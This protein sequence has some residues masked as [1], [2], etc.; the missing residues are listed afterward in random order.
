MD[1]STSS[2]LPL[3]SVKPD[4]GFGAQQNSF[5]SALQSV[6]S[7]Q[8]PPSVNITQPIQFNAPTVIVQLKL[9]DTP[10][11]LIC[12]C[13]RAEVITKVILQNTE[14]TWERFKRILCWCPCLCFCC[15]LISCCL[16][17]TKNFRHECPQC[18]THLGTYKP[19]RH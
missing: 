19:S 13:C 8:L 15:A 2:Y 6:E 12:P 18:Q 7:P 17:S 16:K 3:E 5:H 9:G 1:K 14:E 4:E 10:M 11:R